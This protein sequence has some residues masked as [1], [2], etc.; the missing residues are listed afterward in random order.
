MDSFTYTI[1][2]V[3]GILIALFSIAATAG[4]IYA[5]AVWYPRRVNERVAELKTRG[6]QG[7]ATILRLPHRKMNGA[8][9]NALYKIVSIGLEIRVP[10][11]EPYE[12]DKVFTIPTGYVRYLEIGKIVPVWIDPHNPHDPNKIVIHIEPPDDEK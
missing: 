11:V 10:G 3:V 12:I 7:E 4:A 5:I 9:S 2:L 6:K 8:G 1:T